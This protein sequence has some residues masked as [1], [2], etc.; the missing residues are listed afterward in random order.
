MKEEDIMYYNF[1]DISPA[2]LPQDTEYY[3]NVLVIICHVGPK[4]LQE[5]LTRVEDISKIK[6]PRPVCCIWFE[7]EDIPEGGV[8]IELFDHAVVEVNNKTG[9]VCW[10]E[11][12][13]FDCKHLFSIE[14]ILEDYDGDEEN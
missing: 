7:D 3:F 10:Y 4:T 5:G 2:A 8:G 12:L 11:M 6:D 1:F 13:D 9:E 14:P